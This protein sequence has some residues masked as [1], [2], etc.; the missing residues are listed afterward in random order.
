MRE[1]SPLPLLP[2][3]VKRRGKPGRPELAKAS[4]RTYTYTFTYPRNPCNEPNNIPARS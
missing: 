2:L 4:A 1:S 3:A